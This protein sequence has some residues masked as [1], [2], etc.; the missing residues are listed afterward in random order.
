MKLERQM[1][2]PYENGHQE[3]FRQTLFVWKRKFLPWPHRW[4]GGASFCVCLCSVEPEPNLRVC[5]LHVVFPCLQEFHVRQTATYCRGDFFTWDPKIT[6]FPGLYL[7]AAALAPL[8]R[9]AAVI[10]GALSTPSL[11][12]GKSGTIPHHTTK[13]LRGTAGCQSLCL[14]LQGLFW[15]AHGG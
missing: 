9:E 12:D 3:L 1:E 14:E 6:T 4:E 2:F 10:A 11:E 13:S 7:I 5:I 8:M 15:L